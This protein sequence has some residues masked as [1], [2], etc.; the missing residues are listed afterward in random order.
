VIIYVRIADSVLEDADWG[1]AQLTLEAGVVTGYRVVKRGVYELPDMM[2]WTAEQLTEWS[3]HDPTGH[4]P[5]E[6]HEVSQNPEGPWVD[7]WKPIQ[8]A[9]CHSC[10]KPVQAGA[11]FITHDN[12]GSE[13]RP[14][15]EPVGVYCS[16][17]CCR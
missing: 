14:K 4:H 3:A 16:W 2:G 17:E 10:G 12:R 8:T 9:H 15:Y 7:F 6:Y 11:G 13:R 1:V 5:E